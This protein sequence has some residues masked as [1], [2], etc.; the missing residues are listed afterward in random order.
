MRV[1]IHRA[2]I[3]L[4]LEKNGI[5]PSRVGTRSFR[6]GGAMALKFSGADSDDIKKM[7]DGYWTPS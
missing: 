7:V 3:A 6:L 5:L 1:T 2:V 4:K